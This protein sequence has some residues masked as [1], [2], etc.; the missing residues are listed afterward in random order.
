MNKYIIVFLL[1]LVWNPLLADDNIFTSPKIALKMID[2]KDT[3]FISLDKASLKIK[4]SKNINIRMLEPSN[5]LGY[6][7]CLPFYVCADKIKDYFS[8]LGINSKQA[9]V[10]YDNSYGINAATL[11]VILESIGHKN[12]SI[13]RGTLRDISVLDPNWKIYHEYLNELKTLDLNGTLLEKKI[14][15]LKPHLLLQD[16]NVIE[17]EDIKSDYEI[18]ETKSEYFL[19]KAELKEAVDKVHLSESNIT[20]IDACEMMDIFG[21]NTN[22]SV[23]GIKSLSWRKL[24][25]KKQKY[26]KSN[27]VLEKLFTE[28]ELEKSNNNYIYCMSSAKKAFYVMMALRE[29]G[30][31]KVKVFTG[32]WNTWIG[33]INE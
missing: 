21:N 28:L 19:S 6:L 12:I 10:I 25:D 29:V 23:A 18:L 31:S 15:I 8:G 9:L 5:V 14:N 13:L 2:K 11:Y 26:L 30:Y 22:S 24:I 27:D 7:E 16:S 17:V 1:S 20:I 4:K 3:L 32:D 33:D